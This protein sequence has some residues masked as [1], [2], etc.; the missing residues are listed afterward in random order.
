MTWLTSY[1]SRHAYKKK[2]KTAE[3]SMFLEIRYIHIIMYHCI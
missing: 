3:T 2:K 1:G